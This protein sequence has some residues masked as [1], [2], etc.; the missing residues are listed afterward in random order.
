MCPEKDKKDSVP[1]HNVKTKV[2]ACAVVAE[3]LRS[4]LPSNIACE[5][6][7]FGLHRS[8][9]L[10]RA[11]LQDTINRSANFPNIV[12]A[13]GLC[14]M[15]VIGLSSAT[16]TL[17]LPRADDC[18]AVFLGSRK[19]YLNQQHNFPGS[20]FLSK[21]WIEGRIDNADPTDTIYRTLLEKYGVERAKRMLSVYEARQPLRNY[22]RIAFITTASESDLDHYKDIARRRAADLGLDYKEIV[23]S[24]SFMDKI[25]HGTWDEE[26]VVAPPGH[27]L[28]FDDF[29]PDAT[30]TPLPPGTSEPTNKGFPGNFFP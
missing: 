20:L 10:L 26:F 16:S 5:V 19:A 7:D 1:V 29:W 18:I 14:G 24:T 17:I 2:I 6:L 28:G 15:S 22:K 23:G 4:R 9:D 11:K 3:E 25:A 12:L 27:P 30:Q 8:P 13:Y 21:G